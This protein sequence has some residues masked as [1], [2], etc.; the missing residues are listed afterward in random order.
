MKPGNFEFETSFS[1]VFQS[2]EQQGN[3]KEPRMGSLKNFVREYEKVTDNFPYESEE[4]SM[5]KIEDYDPQ[6]FD[7]G[8]TDI[9]PKYF[10]TKF[11][12][13]IDFT[14]H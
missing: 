6:S 9:C 2:P 13:T 11:I 7:F 5:G 3:V 10:R 1:D 12:I 8:Q 14:F 4:I